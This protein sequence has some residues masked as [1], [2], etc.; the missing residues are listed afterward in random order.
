MAV[1]IREMI[2]TR[3]R[4]MPRWEVSID[5]RVIGWVRALRIAGANLTFY[6]ATG[7]DPDGAS[8]VL[9]CSSDREER[10]ARVIVFDEDPE[11][12]RGVHWHP[13]DG[14]RR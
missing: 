1:T 9:E 14:G 12:W 4:E 11:P 7:I 13:R 3:E 5:G 8:V 2:R 10:I 6:E